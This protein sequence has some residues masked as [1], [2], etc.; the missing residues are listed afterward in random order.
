M[1]SIAEPQLFAASC[2]P[3]S[4]VTVSWLNDMRKASFAITIAKLI[5]EASKCMPSALYWQVDCLFNT[6]ASELKRMYT[7]SRDTSAP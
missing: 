7:T 2:T 4:E 3:K 5:F 1:T 6:P